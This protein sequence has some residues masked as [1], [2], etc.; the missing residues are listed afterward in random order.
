M[1]IYNCADT[2]D[3]AIESVLNQTYKNW[4][5][6]MCDDCSTDNTYNIAKRYS[7]KYDNI[8]LLKNEKNMRLAYSLNRC[9]EVSRG[10]YIARMD[11]DDENMPE[12][13]EKQVEFLNNH[14]EYSVVS[15]RAVIFD[16]NKENTVR[17]KEGEPQKEDMI[18]GAPFMHPTIMMR[19]KAYD[20]LNGYTVSDRTKRGQDLDLWFRFF[21]EGF[22]GY[23]TSDVLYKYHESP[24]D[25]KKRTLKTAYGYTKTNLYGYRLL[26]FPKYK[27]IMAFKP[28]I[29][30]IVPNF[31]MI[32][33]KKKR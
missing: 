21:K 29:S 28:F 9:L 16:G 24:S 17:G 27:W 3:E 14:K 7:D 4:E 8:V 15:C 11:A 5:L 18:K 19:K 25:F 22:R 10:E 6:V 12:R 30:A 20:K 32:I 2:L 13:L 26:E 23:I 33:Y 1:G 31:I